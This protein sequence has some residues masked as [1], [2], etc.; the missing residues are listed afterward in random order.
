[1]ARAVG[2]CSYPFVIKLRSCSHL[3]G[4][5]YPLPG[6]IAFAISIVCAF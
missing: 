5:G 2:L 3:M 6:G 4:D 1:M